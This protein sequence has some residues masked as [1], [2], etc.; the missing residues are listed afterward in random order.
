MT[1]E[2][3]KERHTGQAGL[4]ALLEVSNG[5]AE[6]CGLEPQR[7]TGV[8]DARRLVLPKVCLRRRLL[9]RMLTLLDGFADEVKALLLGDGFDI[10]A[11]GAARHAELGFDAAEVASVHIGLIGNVILWEVYST[12]SQSCASRAA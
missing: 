6:A 4:I 8:L 12:S 10:D 5:L 11:L 3:K 7:S 2:R 9:D 1:P